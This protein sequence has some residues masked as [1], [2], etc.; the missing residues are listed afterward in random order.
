MN[1]FILDENPVK[2]AKMQ[3]DKHVVKMIIESAQMLCTTHR[4]LDGKE[5]IDYSKNGRKITRWDHWTDPPMESSNRPMLYKSVMINHP[6]TIWT[7]ESWDNYYWHVEHAL[8]L[9]AEYT[10][11][12]RKVHATEK[13]IRWCKKYAPRNR[14][15]R[16]NSFFGK[17][18]TPFAQAMPDHYKV[19]GDAV[20]AYRNYY[21][22]D[23]ARFA[24][25]KE[26]SLV[27]EWFSEGVL[28]SEP[29]S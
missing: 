6:C 13:I 22:G 3:C 17:G 24:K 19:S 16:S 25:W 4:Y 20:Q 15:S 11:R 9:C 28:E 26:S 8:E 10:R 14:R 21:I 2:A 23:K 5:W 27:P 29:I 18:L 7:C 1:I 12:Y